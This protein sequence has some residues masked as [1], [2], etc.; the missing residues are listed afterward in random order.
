MI[1]YGATGP[2]PN[3]GTGTQE[4]HVAQALTAL[5]TMTK[6]LYE[7]M[8]KRDSQGKIDKSSA[9]LTDGQSA[10]KRVQSIQAAIHRQSLQEMTWQ[11]SATHI[12]E[13][14]AGPWLPFMNCKSLVQRFSEAVRAEYE[15]ASTVSITALNMARQAEEADAAARVKLVLPPGSGASPTI[16]DYRNINDNFTEYMRAICE[17]LAQ[18]DAAKGKLET[19]PRQGVPSHYN[20]LVG[21]LAALKTY[22][23]ASHLYGAPG[24]EIMLWRNMYVMIQYAL[25]NDPT[26]ENKRM[27]LTLNLALPDSRGIP[28]S[29]APAAATTVSIGAAGMAGSSSKGQK[30]TRDSTKSGSFLGPGERFPETAFMLGG[31]GTPCS[32]SCHECGENTHHRVECPFAF[33]REWGVAAPGFEAPLKHGMKQQ[34]EDLRKLD[35]WALGGLVSGPSDMVLREWVKHDWNPGDQKLR[36]QAQGHVTRRKQFWLGWEE[37]WRKFS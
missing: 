1:G 4:T 30:T 14:G 9:T 29:V 10:E 31:L 8:D 17:V 28:R 24:C 12:G 36:N 16:H 5:M 32:G 21:N 35:Y 26:P 34:C 3:V 7:D 19:P 18:A 22:W 37:A 2:P 27:M 6:K 15:G 20:A 23:S 33:F 11:S 25:G 13:N